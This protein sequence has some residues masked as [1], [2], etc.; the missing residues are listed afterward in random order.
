MRNHLK[1]NWILILGTTLLIS[2][3]NIKLNPTQPK[4]V[5]ENPILQKIIILKEEIVK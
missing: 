3:I 1:K 5:Q 4:L 2:I